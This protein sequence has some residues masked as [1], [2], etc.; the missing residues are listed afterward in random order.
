MRKNGQNSTSSQIFNNKFEILMGG[1][2]F[3]YEFWWS[4]REDLYV[5]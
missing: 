4:F 5:F 2:L 3:E 1:F